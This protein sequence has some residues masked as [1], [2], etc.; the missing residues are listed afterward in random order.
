LKEK[1]EDNFFDKEKTGKKRKLPRQAGK[2]RDGKVSGHFF[3]PL[4]I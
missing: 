4:K 1:N 2:G 3:I